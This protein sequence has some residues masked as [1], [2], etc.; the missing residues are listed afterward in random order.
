MKTKGFTFIELLIALAIFAIMAASIYYTLNTGIR[1]YTSGNSVI[2]GNQDLRVFF[3]EI[4]ADL[5]NAPAGFG[6]ESGF[7]IGSEWTS[8]KI[9]FPTL[10][11]I[12]YGDVSGKELAKVVYNFDSRSGKLV[13]FRAGLEAGFNE[14]LLSQQQEEILLEKSENFPL[15]DL[16]FEYSYSSAGSEDEYEWR[17]TW[18]SKGKIPR[19]VKVRVALKR[20]RSGAVEVFEKIIFLPMGVLGEEGVPG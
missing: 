15:E 9:S 10:I 11:N 4:S 6:M 7:N 17:D 12:R 2:S 18:E 1:V 5:A 19:G 8:Q 14:E 13:R 20:K 16:T 3:E